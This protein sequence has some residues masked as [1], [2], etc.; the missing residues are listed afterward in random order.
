MSLLFGDL[1]SCV[2]SIVQRFKNKES[3]ADFTEYIY[4]LLVGKAWGQRLIMETSHFGG[5][6]FETSSICMKFGNKS[7][8]M[9]CFNPSD[10]LNQ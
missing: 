6:S 5:F 7:L 8:N 1:E 3:L 4:K 2:Q 9:F 10:V